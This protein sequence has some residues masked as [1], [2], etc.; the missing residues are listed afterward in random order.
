MRPAPLLARQAL[1]ELLGSAGL[2]TVVIGSGIAAQRLSPGDTGV[3]LLE[4]ALI[5]GCGLVAL[6]LAV[7][8]GADHPALLARGRHQLVRLDRAIADEDDLRDELGRQLG[9][10]VTALTVQELDLV[11]DTTLVDVRYRRPRPSAK[12]ATALRGELALQGAVR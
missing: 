1:A 6:I 3:E 9:G 5:T 12:A 4:N 8:W 2:V 11:N 10:V 7:L